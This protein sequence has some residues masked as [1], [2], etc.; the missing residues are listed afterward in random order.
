MVVL[1]FTDSTQ[2]ANVPFPANGSWTDLLNPN[3]VLQISNYWA[4]N[5]PI[6]SN[7]GCLFLQRGNFRDRATPPC[8]QASA[9]VGC[10]LQD[11]N[12]EE[13]S[14]VAFVTRLAAF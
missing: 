1:N 7:W 8:K 3:T 11:L 4:Y 10:H 14:R 13:E 9:F 2:Y 5:Y 12:E 6:P